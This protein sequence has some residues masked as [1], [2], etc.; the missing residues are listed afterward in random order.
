MGIIK[1]ISYVYGMQG[2]AR[3]SA[4]LRIVTRDLD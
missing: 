3:T 2:I 4:S 1:F